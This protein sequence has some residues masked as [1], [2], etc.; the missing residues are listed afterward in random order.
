MNGSEYLIDTNIA[1]Y[2]LSGDQTLASL[3]HQKRIYLS[4]ISEIEL[5]GF[6]P[7]SQSQ[8]KKSGR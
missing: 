8:K 3:L 6:I 2:L 1:L 5:L 4:I 7:M